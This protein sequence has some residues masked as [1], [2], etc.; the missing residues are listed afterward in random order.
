MTSSILPMIEMNSFIPWIH[1]INK[2]IHFTSH[3]KCIC[4]PSPMGAQSN[5]IERV[6]GSAQ[7]I[8]SV[9]LIDRMMECVKFRENCKLLLMMRKRLIIH[10]RNWNWIRRRTLCLPVPVK[11]KAMRVDWIRVGLRVDWFHIRSL[12]SN[13][14]HMVRFSNPVD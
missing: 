10:W 3:F 5:W 4:I 13:K 14:L 6:S 2:F 9:L 11:R 12:T 7:T 1:R 8:V